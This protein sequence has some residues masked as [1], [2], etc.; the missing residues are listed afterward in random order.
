MAAY[1]I[2]FTVYFILLL[3]LN[4]KNRFFLN[5]GIEAKTINLLFGI[6]IILGLVYIYIE[7]HTNKGQDLDIFFNN[8]LEQTNLLLN[9]PIQFITSTFSSNYTNNNMSG[10][11]STQSYWNDIRNIFIEKL[12]GIINILSFKNLYINSL[13]Y[14]YLIFFGHIALYRSFYNIYPNVKTGILLGCFFIPSCA[15]YLSGINKDSMFFLGM[16]LIIFSISHSFFLKSGKLNKTAIVLMVSGLLITLII[17]NFFF[18]LLIPAV[19]AYYLSVNFNQ[20]PLL[21]F[22]AV[23]S[24]VAVLFFCSPALMQ[25]VCN[26]QADFL[27][28]GWARS[29]VA[30]DI[31]QPN[32][33]SFITHLPSVINIAFLRP[34]VWDSYSISYFASAIEIILLLTL[35]L[36]STIILFKYNRDIFNH[37]LILCCIFYAVSAFLVI[38]FT[39]P[40]L[41]AVVRYKTAFLPILITPFLIAIPWDRLKFLKLL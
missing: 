20:K 41:G 7:Q 24:T 13:F 15:Y 2:L 29:A 31:L 18:V 4:K 28:L 10:L 34:Y 30:V 27:H 1:F 22:T 35:V 40:F 3:I 8:S 25:I 5:S 16:S 33:K 39:I 12:L 32:I 37:P 17:R 21:I 14:N 26:R 6:K 36:Y 38:G 19:L 11:F 9:H 23:F